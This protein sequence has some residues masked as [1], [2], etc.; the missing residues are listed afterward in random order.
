MGFCNNSLRQKVTLTPGNLWTALALLKFSFIGGYLSGVSRY[1]CCMGRSLTQKGTSV[2]ARLCRLIREFALVV[3]FDLNRASF[4]VIHAGCTDG[5]RACI[6]CW[7]MTDGP[8]GPRIWSLSG[9]V[10]SWSAFCI[11]EG[12]ASW[13]TFLLTDQP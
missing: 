11:C 7:S 4:L 5:A 9:F 2:D 1:G 10:T 8:L 13:G 6:D 12:L 3:G